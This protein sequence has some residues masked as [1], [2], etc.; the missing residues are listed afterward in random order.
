MLVTGFIE[1]RRIFSKDFC[2]SLL[3]RSIKINFFHLLG[4]SSDPVIQVETD[5]TYT[6]DEYID[7]LVL[8]RNVDNANIGQRDPQLRND[9]A[10]VSGSFANLHCFVRSG[11]YHKRNHYCK[12]VPHFLPYLLFRLFIY[13]LH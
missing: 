5:E 11:N 8:S 3:V 4:T 10:V 6:T 12:I 13:Y 7:S 1:K 2:R 9:S